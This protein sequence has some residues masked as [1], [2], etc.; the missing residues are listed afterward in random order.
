MIDTNS[1]FSESNVPAYFQDAYLWEQATP[2]LVRDVGEGY[3]ADIRLKSR[4]K[5]TG[6]GVIT[7]SVTEGGPKKRKGPGD[8]EG[9]V[10]ILLMDPGEGVPDDYTYTD[11][12]GVFRFRDVALGKYEVMPEIAGYKITSKELELTKENPRADSIDFSK[13]SSNRQITAIFYNYSKFNTGKLTVYPNPVRDYL[14]VDYTSVKPGMVDV[15]LYNSLG[16][17]KLHAAH[18]ARPGKNTFRMDVCHLKEGL[19]FLEF[20]MIDA[21]GERKRAT[22]KVPVAR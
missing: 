4:T 2:V 12:N 10:E 20:R 15:K 3:P 18:S 6:K 13:D 8:P 19:Y 16:Q 17:E 5:E 11:S 14:S 21:Y 1:A 9:G 7:G 22:L